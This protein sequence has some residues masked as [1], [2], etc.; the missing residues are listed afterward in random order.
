MCAV[1][2]AAESRLWQ[3]TDGVFT[4]AV[5]VVLS[6][7]Y[8]QDRFYIHCD[9]ALFGMMMP[10]IKEV[11]VACMEQGWHSLGMGAVLILLGRLPQL[12]VLLSRSCRLLSRSQQL[13]L[14]T[15]ISQAQ[16]S[17]QVDLI[18]EGER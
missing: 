13:L 7:G 14:A 16:Y 5:S 4:V 15:C 18:S 12:H 3:G 11:G 10:F 1:R 8:T 17:V 9:G 2:H 6:T